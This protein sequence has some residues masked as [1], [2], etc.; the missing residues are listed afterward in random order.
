MGPQPAFW[1][2][3]IS[4]R[5]D[6]VTGFM[7]KA[8]K[9]VMPGPHWYLFALGTKIGMH[10]KGC[11][12]KLMDFATK[13]ADQT[14]HPMY[15]E[16]YGPGNIRLYQKY[17]FAVQVQQEIVAKGNSGVLSKHGGY[18]AMVRPKLGEEKQ[19]LGELHGVNAAS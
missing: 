15:L 17:N 13:C 4:R 14:G 1:D 16:T 9:E 3:H 18:A 11:G 5:L 6:A 10:G 2:A 8:H 7:S 19:R 12:S